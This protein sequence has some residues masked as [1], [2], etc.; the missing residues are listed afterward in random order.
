VLVDEFVKMIEI[1][2]KEVDKSKIDAFVTK[3]ALKSF[4]LEVERHKEILLE[5]IAHQKSQLEQLQI[6]NRSLE[7]EQNQLEIAAQLNSQ[8][9]K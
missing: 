3:N 1:V 6:E 7:E 9:A 2:S 4:E 8:D 5:Q